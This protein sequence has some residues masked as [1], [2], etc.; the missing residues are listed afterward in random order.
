LGGEGDFY[1]DAGGFAAFEG[2]VEQD[3]VVAWVGEVVL[4]AA[5][6]GEGG[7]GQSIVGLAALEAVE[8]VFGHEHDAHAG[9]AGNDLMGD[10]YGGGGVLDVE[11]HASPLSAGNGY[12]FVEERGGSG[13]QEGGKH[14]NICYG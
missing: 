6:V 1:L 3:A 9:A 8:F 4:E 11:A 5:F 13:Q 7:G 12:G 10:F 2:V 14:Y